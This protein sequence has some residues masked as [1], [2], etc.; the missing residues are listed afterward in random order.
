MQKIKITLNGKQIEI[1]ANTSIENLAFE[2]KLN[3]QRCLVELNG[4]AMNFNKFKNILLNDGDTLEI[5]SLV[6]GG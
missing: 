3:P 1:N 2:L 6:A 5:M 4:I